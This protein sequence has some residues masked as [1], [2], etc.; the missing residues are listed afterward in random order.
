[1]YTV[2]VTGASGYIGQRLVQR[3]AQEPTIDRVLAM[4]IRPLPF[5]QEKVLFLRH[6]V[7]E[8]FAEI[9]VQHRIRLAAHL[10]FIVD[11]IYD[12][13]R[14]R[15]V[16]VGGSRNFLDAC[17]AAGVEALLLSS[18]ATV[19]GALPD[20]PPLLTED[21]PLRARP[22]FPYVEDKLVQEAMA[23]Q[24]AQEHPQARLIIT[25]ATVVT[26]PHMDNFMS[27]YFSRA[28]AFTI[29]GANPLVP[30][31]HEDDTAEATARLLLRAPS[32]AYNINAPNAVPL[33]E[34]IQ[35]M[36]ARAVALPP[37]LIYPL[38]TLGWKLRLRFLTEVPPRMLDYIRYSWNVDGSKVTRFTD[39][40]YHYDG[41]ASMEAF[42]AGRRRS[43]P[44][45]L[46]R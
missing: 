36:G 13:Q 16:N 39:F 20:N 40:R 14:E 12:R 30:L 10:A 34:V 41:R 5:Q 28:L 7:S 27:R 23:R 11:P 19:Y 42:L 33:Q 24:Y 37:V 21:S 46:S 22:G 4:D 25:R 32:G 31:V 18:S 35:K 43:R 3:L 15:R 44:P 17:H 29:R 6:D 2:A 9:F 45:S 38:A 1:M 26:G 8:P